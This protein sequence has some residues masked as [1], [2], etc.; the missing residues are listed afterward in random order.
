MHFQCCWERQLL[1]GLWEAG[2]KPSIGTSPSNHCYHPSPNAI[3][4][5]KNFI[6]IY[7]N[8]LWIRGVCAYANVGAHRVHKSVSDSLELGLQVVVNQHTCWEL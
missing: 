2:D 1:W 7:F 4:T 6:S 8:S 3:M 5:L